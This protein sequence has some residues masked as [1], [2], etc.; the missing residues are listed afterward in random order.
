[1]KY[2]KTRDDKVVDT[3]TGV[4]P[5]GYINVNKR[6]NNP[7]EY[8]FGFY[9]NKSSE[10]ILTVVNGEVFED[11][12]FM[13]KDV[14]LIQD[15]IYNLI[16]EKR[17]KRLFK[18]FDVESITVTIESKEQ[19]RDIKGLD[20]ESDVYKIKNKKGKGRAKR[21]KG[22]VK[23]TALKKAVNKHVN[24]QYKWEDTQGDLVE[25]MTTIDELNT[26]VKSLQ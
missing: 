16:K 18:S 14:D 17:N 11:F 20:D 9:F 19:I 24:K 12:E 1:M 23:I 2:A 21:I 7:T 10:P 22:K 26:Y 5:E 15:H 6:W 25:A 3:V 4:K 8:P 13:L